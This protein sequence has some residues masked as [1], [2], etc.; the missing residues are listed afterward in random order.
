M[1]KYTQKELREFCRFGM[2][3]NITN[4]DAS[5]YVGRSFEKIGYSR[6]VYGLNGGLLQDR[7]TGERFAI[8]GRSTNLFVFF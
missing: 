5:Q 4:A 6:G 8:I 7:E 3:E 2:A 1:R